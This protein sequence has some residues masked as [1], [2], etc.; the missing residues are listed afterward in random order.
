MISASWLRVVSHGKL[1][2]NRVS[3][4]FVITKILSGRLHGVKER[5]NGQEPVHEEPGS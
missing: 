2:D 4:A 1:P 3:T 5:E